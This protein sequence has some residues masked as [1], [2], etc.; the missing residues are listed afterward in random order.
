MLRWRIAILVA[1]AIAIN[2][3]DRLTLPSVI[4]YMPRNMQFGNQAFALLNTAFLGA[5][6]AMYLLGGR[7]LDLLGTRR[8]FI[9]II[10][11][12]SLAC[13]SHGF[14]N[15]LVALII[16]RLLLGIGEGGGFP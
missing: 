13:A 8:G 2:Y 16:C 9:G 11:I 10:V 1:M 14:A 12:W 3:L 4:D 6:G 7:M 15:G 5:Y